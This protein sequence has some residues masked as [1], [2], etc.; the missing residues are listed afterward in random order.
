MIFE[1]KIKVITGG[2]AGI[3]KAMVEE[4]LERGVVVSAC[5]HTPGKLSWLK[6]EFTGKALPTMVAVV[7]TED[8]TLF[9]R[10]L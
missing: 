3:W 5:P 10:S 2:T 7:S 9:F 6:N 1:N 8:A 4:F